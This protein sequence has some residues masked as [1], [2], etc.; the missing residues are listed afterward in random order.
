MEFYQYNQYAIAKAQDIQ[1]KEKADELKVRL[2]P[3]ASV[4]TLADAQKLAKE[5]LPTSQ[6][7]TSF[8]VG[9]AKCSVV[10]KPDSFRISVDTADEFICYDFS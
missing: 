9:K 8:Y 2:L 4:E 5:I 7:Y 3:F 10:N 6:A 1:D